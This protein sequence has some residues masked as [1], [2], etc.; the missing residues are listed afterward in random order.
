MI[1]TNLNR[2]LWTTL[3]TLAVLCAAG[4]SSAADK[5]RISVTNFNM[6]FLPA[7]LAVK[8]GFFKEEGLE[9]EVIRMNANVAVAALAGGD[10]DYTMV[11]G[12][13]VRAA[14]RGL[15]LKVVA[16]FID[17]STHALIARPEFRS[18]KELKGK[19][20][21][22]QAYGASDHVAALMMFKRLGVDAEKEMKVVA[23]GSASGRLAGLK[24]GVIEVAVISP[25]TDE[26]AR[27]LGFRILAR[28]NELFSFPF[29]GLGTQVKKIKEKPD[30]VKRTIKAFVKANRYLR[31]NREGTIQTLSE[32][33]RTMP[34]LAAAAY[35]SS[36][37]VYNMDGAIPE[38]GLRAVIE[39]AVKELKI[40]REVV[41]GEVAD[42]GPLREAQREL[43][44]KAR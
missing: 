14:I 1:F 5:I 29:V 43:G 33:G 8:K 16:S 20:L 9:A 32:W 42:L 13:V 39:Q 15:P 27:Q 37:K 11:F 30:E 44:I 34:D 31:Q 26:E 38:D 18:V 41:P 10:T 17:S 28:A 3:L 24:E 21:G 7:G 4:N 19:T 36:Y 6:S 23:L 12:S 40:S 22:V 25:P 2:R 35:D